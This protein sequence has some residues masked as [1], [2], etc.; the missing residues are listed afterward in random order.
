[1]A[2]DSGYTL[3]QTPG[4]LLLRTQ[5][6]LKQVLRNWGWGRPQL[7]F[8]L[9]GVKG[10]ALE[11]IAWCTPVK[12]HNEAKCWGVSLRPIYNFSSKVLASIERNCLSLLP[13]SPRHS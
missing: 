11:V 13:I 7:G 5:E 8:V 6:K 12:C 9:L 10:N 4:F 1:V 2:G 3:E